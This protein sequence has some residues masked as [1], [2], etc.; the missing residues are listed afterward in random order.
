MR[1]ILKYKIL[2]KVRYLLTLP[3]R[4]RFFKRPKWNFLK[5]L[6]FRKHKKYASRRYKRKLPY[7]DNKIKFVLFRKWRKLKNSF[8]QHIFSKRFLLVGLNHNKR[9]FK[10]LKSNRDKTY[11]KSL[12][13]FFKQQYFLDYMLFR[14]KYSAS[15]FEAGEILRRKKIFLN[16]EIGNKKRILKKGDFVFIDNNLYRYKI[17]GRKYT[18]T[19]LV[20][21]FY[22]NDFY[23]QSFIVTKNI[24]DISNVDF[25]VSYGNFIKFNALK[26]I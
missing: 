3:L 15:I 7:P 24:Q 12:R 1:L 10:N 25:G 6:L 20:D 21:T 26:R 5:K 16:K 11:L 13:T 23:T 19:D 2:T 17:T 22:E 18:Y 8:K 9:C 14:V 4:I